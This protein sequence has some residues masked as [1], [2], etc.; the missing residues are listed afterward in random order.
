[1]QDVT[2]LMNRYREA[3]RLLWNGFLRNPQANGRI[4]LVD[5]RYCD[6]HR[7][8]DVL[9]VAL[10]LRE[11]AHVETDVQF[12]T[13]NQPVLPFLR[14]VATP[15]SAILVNRE[16]AHSRN[17]YWDGAPTAVPDDIDLRFIDYFDWDVVG[18]RDLA[19]YLTRIVGC[20]EHPD[21]VGRDA[22]LPVL[23]GRVVVVKP[24]ERG[25]GRR[26][27]APDTPRRSRRVLPLKSS[28]PRPGTR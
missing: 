16:V 21:I 25:R 10:V 26:L 2:E 1:M 28:R 14:I 18:Y 13:V 23:N 7:M 8:R 9:F 24:N 19:Y 17:Q 12:G 20:P 11:I 5:E 3:C 27:A 4:S 15:R 6:F 22:L